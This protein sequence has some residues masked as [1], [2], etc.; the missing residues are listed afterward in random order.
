M[1][2]PHFIVLQQTKNSCRYVST[3]SKSKLELGFHFSLENDQDTN[4]NLQRSDLCGS[5]A[6]LSSW[7]SFATINLILVHFLMVTVNVKRNGVLN[8]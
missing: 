1:L 8:G 6:D 4:N 2:L 5:S 3:T 7:S